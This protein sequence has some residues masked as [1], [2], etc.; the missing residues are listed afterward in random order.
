MRVVIKIVL[1]VVLFVIGSVI[2]AVIKEGMGTRHSTGG[3]GPF[4][5][6]PALMAGIYAIWKY[7][8]EDKKG[9]SAQNEVLK[10]D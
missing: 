10:K 2:L 4:I 7:N 9:A 6:Y 5:I 8:P 3:I 1:S